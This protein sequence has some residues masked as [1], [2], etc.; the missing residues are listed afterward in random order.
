MQLGFHV[1]PE[2]LEQGCLKSCCLSVGYVLLD[3]L[4][5][6]ASVRQNAHSL[7]EISCV[8]VGEYPEGGPQRRRGWGGRGRI[9]GGGSQEVGQ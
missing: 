2:Q 7:T 4:P 5:C 9:V 1:G 6:I 3:G 8:R